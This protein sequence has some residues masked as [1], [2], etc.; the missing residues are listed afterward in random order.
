MEAEAGEGENPTEGE[1]GGGGKEHFQMGKSMVFMR[2]EYYYFLEEARKHMAGFAAV[3]IQATWRGYVVKKWYLNYR[4]Q[5]FLFCLVFF[6]F[7][8]LI[9]DQNLALFNPSLVFSR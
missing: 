5:V 6:F 1:V 7:V 2:E 3:L 9:V 8:D 4:K